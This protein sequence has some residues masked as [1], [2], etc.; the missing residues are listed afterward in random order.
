MESKSFK[1]ALIAKHRLV[2]SLSPS[3]SA[4]KPNASFLGVPQQFYLNNLGLRLALGE[5]GLHRLDGFASFNSVH[6]TF[7]LE[8]ALDGFTYITRRDLFH[9]LPSKF[10]FIGVLAKLFGR[11]L[12]LLEG[13][14]H[15]R[16]VN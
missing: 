12:G 10:G 11:R 16:I 1:L 7:V 3:S 2:A 14:S 9:G 8:A 13:I 5:D 15:L 4:P 6:E